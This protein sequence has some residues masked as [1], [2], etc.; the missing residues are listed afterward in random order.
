MMKCKKQILEFP[1]V[2]AKPPLAAVADDRFTGENA[3]LTS[4]YAITNLSLDSLEELQ[5]PQSFP[6]SLTSS[7]PPSGHFLAG[8]PQQKS[9]DIPPK[10]LVSLGFEGH[11]ELFGPHPFTWKTATPLEDIRTK[12]FRF[13]FLSLP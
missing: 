10:S 1:M 2:L 9:R 13:G 4:A 3:K 11:T 5:R 7:T 6:A 12:K 8:Y